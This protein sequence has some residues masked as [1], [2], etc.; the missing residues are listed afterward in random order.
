MAQGTGIAPDRMA[1]LLQAGAAIGLLRRRRDGRF[2]LARGRGAPRGAGARGDDPASPRLLCGHGRS[3][4]APARRGRD[5]AGAVLAL[6]LRRAAASPRRMPSALLGPDGAVAGR[7]WPQ[8]TPAH[9]VAARGVAA[10][11]DVGGG[12]GAFL[13]AVARRYP[14]LD[15]RS[16]TCRRCAE[17]QRRLAQAG[18]EDRITCGRIVPLRCP[19]RGG[20]RDFARAGSLRPRRC[21]GARPAGQGHAALPPGGRLIVSEPMS[22]GARPDPGRRRLFRLLYH[23]D[24]DRARALGRD[25]RA[26]CAARRDSDRSGSRARAGRCHQCPDLHQAGL[27]YF[28]GSLCKVRL[29][30]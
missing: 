8:D 25:H 19:A 18:L 23:G 15:L 26:S 5:R 28:S 3:R 7:S 1:H 21:D 16:S 29:T 24:G 30:H 2:G 4:G 17:A 13:A 14:K 9:G 6:C 22:G 12:S 20:R 27:R 10:L 11:M